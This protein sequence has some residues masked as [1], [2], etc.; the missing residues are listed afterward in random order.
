MS[1]MQRDKGAAFERE[2][3]AYLSMITGRDIKRTLGQARDG[4]G[5]IHIEPLGMLIECKRRAR[6]DTLY[7]WLQQAQDACLPAEF[8]VVVARGDNKTAVV[9][10]EMA[11]FIGL[12]EPHFRRIRPV[13][14]EGADTTPIH[15]SV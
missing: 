1:K 10:M 6:I 3:A 14:Y 9:I 4:G 11:T 7:K 13:N 15:P 2:I 12:M 8:P 5:D